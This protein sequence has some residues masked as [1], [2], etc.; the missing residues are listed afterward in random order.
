MYGNVER[1]RWYLDHLREPGVSVVGL[2]GI[3]V[4]DHSDMPRLRRIPSLGAG[5]TRDGA[6]S[7]PCLSLAV[8]LVF[9]SIR[10]I[11]FLSEFTV[12]IMSLFLNW[13]FTFP[14]KCSQRYFSAQFHQI[15]RDSGVWATGFLASPRAPRVTSM[16]LLLLLL[17]AVFPFCFHFSKLKSC[18][19]TNSPVCMLSVPER[20]LDN[21]S[22]FLLYLNSPRIFHLSI[23]LNILLLTV[24]GPTTYT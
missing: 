6:L 15:P 24:L 14:V 20:R 7:L 13:F 18:W 9:H 21:F 8:P 3:A 22:F 17:L 5:A 23:F 1:S 19:S 16:A 4:R 12:F 2:C 11:L 10:H